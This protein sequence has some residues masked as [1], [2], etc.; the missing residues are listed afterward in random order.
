MPRWPIPF[1]VGNSTI[2]GKGLFSKICLRNRQKIGEFAGELISIREARRRA[3]S[4]KSIAIVELNNGKAIDGTRNGNGFR[5]INHSCS[6][7][8]FMR[9]FRNIMEFYALR[10]IKSGEE[11]T[12][13]YGESHHSG[14]RPCSCGSRKCR[15]AI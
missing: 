1:R 14:T 5:Y 15:G 8:T 13:D 9:R 3:K 6:P 2:D 10:D 4:L 11:L 7:N 12:C